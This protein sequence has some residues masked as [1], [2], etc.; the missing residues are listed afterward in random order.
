[1][2]T[3]EQR[4]SIKLYELLKRLGAYE[5]LV[6]IIDALTPDELEECLDNIAYLNGYHWRF[7]D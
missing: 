3:E 6:G 5:T 1:M 7:D 2:L 4:V